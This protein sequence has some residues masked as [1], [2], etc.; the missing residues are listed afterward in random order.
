MSV[1]KTERLAGESKRYEQTLVDWRKQEAAAHDTNVD[2]HQ[3]VASGGAPS[4][5]SSLNERLR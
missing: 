5:T 1:G 4:S 2:L 3:T